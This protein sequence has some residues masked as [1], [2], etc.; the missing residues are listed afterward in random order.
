MTGPGRGGPPDG[1]PDTLQDRFRHAFRRHAAGVVIL[2]CEDPAG[3][4]IGMTA[5]SVCSVSARPPQLLAC[6]DRGS[7]TLAAIT[8]TGRFAVNALGRRHR[9]L[10]EACA[11]PG[12]DKSLDELAVIRPHGRTPMLRNAHAGLGCAVVAVHE[13]ATHSICVGQV[14]WVELGDRDAALVYAAGTYHSVAEPSTLST[15][16]T[17]LGEL[18]RAYS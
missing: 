4:A 17:F 7:R 2:T 13:A 6:L 12:V 5:T 9:E 8:S 11:R 10:S 16:D 18:I 15:E 1:G 3:T 14:E